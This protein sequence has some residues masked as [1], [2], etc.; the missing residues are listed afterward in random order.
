GAPVEDIQALSAQNISMDI[1]IFTSLNP[2]VLK[3]LNVSTVR[4]LLGMNVADL[5]IFENSLMVQSWISQRKQ[6]ELDMLN[7]GIINLDNNSYNP[8]TT[9]S[10]RTATDTTIP[11]VNTPVTFSAILNIS[12]SPTTSFEITPSFETTVN[13]TATTS[14][15]LNSSASPTT[16]FEI[17]PSFETTVNMTASIS[18]ILNTS[19]YPAT[20]IKITT[21]FEN[22]TSVPDNP[23]QGVESQAIETA[24]LY[25]N[26][27]AVLCNFSITDYA[28]SSVSGLSTNDLA[29]LLKCKITGNV[30]YTKD[31]WKLFFHNL[32][33]NLDEALDKV[34]SM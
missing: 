20:S 22:S 4:D 29:K 12:A 3:F 8:I 26:A 7:L 24:L 10:T 30:K 27:S 17:T 11:T 28:C 13:M 5:K 19:A 21:S 31:I 25:E 15:I 9:P 18:E 14:E 32:A 6:S 34:Y 1:S 23:C 16:S 2:S 33:A